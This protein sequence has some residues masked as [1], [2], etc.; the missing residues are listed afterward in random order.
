MRSYDGCW[1]CRLRRKKCDEERPICGVCSALQIT[2]YYDDAK[3]E[4]MDGS[5]KQKEMAEQLKRD[6]K[7]SAARRRET[8][9]IQVLMTDKEDSHTSIHISSAGGEVAV[10]GIVG[11]ELS[12]YQATDSAAS[13][14]SFSPSPSTTGTGSSR[15]HN[16]I[17][18]AD[19]ESDGSLTRVRSEDTASHE[20]LHN[21]EYL[22]AFLDHFFPFLF[23]FYRPAMMEGGRGWVLELTTECQ[24]LWH[25]SI[26]LSAFFISVTL[27]TS[28]SGHKLCKDFVWGKLMKQTNM[29]FK[30]LQLY[31]QDI[32]SRLIQNCLPESARVMGTIVQLQRFEISAGSF[33]NCQT[34]LN[35]ALSLFEQ[36]F[37]AH[38]IEVNQRGEMLPNFNAIID[39]LR[40]S[41][42]DL[43]PRGSRPWSVDQ[44]AF[45]FFTAL[46]LV[47]D[48]V[49]STSLE[50]P[51]KLRGFHVHLL[52]NIE[53]P[54]QEVHLDLEEFVGCQNWLML[55]V[56]EIATLDAWKKE[57]RRAGKLDMMELFTRASRIKQELHDNLSR[58]DPRGSAAKTKRSLPEVFSAYGSSNNN[59]LSSSFDESAFVTRVWA[60]AA[61]A[62]LSVVVSGWQPANA[63]IRENVARVLELLSQMPTPALLRTMAWPF[64]V[65]G[66]LAEPEQEGL[67]R[68]MVGALEPLRAFG[69]A[70][71]AL[72][73]M[74]NVWQNRYTLDPNTWDLAAC[75]RSLGH[76]V[77]LV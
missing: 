39:Q 43:A 65:A 16:A 64:C 75:F 55:L 58:L 26:C 68:S 9:V 18:P 19:S 34:H 8:S 15:P 62:Y 51:P 3:P 23:P 6:V 42:W 20:E 66:C 69:T 2:C 52:T 38:G 53:N 12:P 7:L 41:H 24:A 73:I 27:D 63:N 77:L 61:L 10:S 40:P 45:R 44:A 70:E 21:R 57:L 11:L 49:A 76:M 74:E 33:E 67:L 56:S 4:W 31:L 47:D 46:L 14:S 60:H 59:Q 5:Q 35:A 13:Q 37:R 29:T 36:I 54:D 72:K 17:L 22:M 50:E 30:T 71:K 28:P 1:T 32:N 25:T 48:I